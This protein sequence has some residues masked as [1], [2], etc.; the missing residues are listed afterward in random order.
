MLSNLLKQL[1]FTDNEAKVYLTLFDLGPSKATKIIDSIG[2]HRNLVYTS[3]EKLEKR[4]LV[5]K[6]LV[7]GIAEFSVSDPQILLEELDQQKE[8]AKQAVEELT[9]KQDHE[10]RDIQIFEGLEGI[11]RA[12]NRILTLP[13]DSD[14]YVL[15]A[16]KLTSFPELEAFWRKFHKER[17]LKGINQKMLYD[18]SDDSN[19]KEQMEWRNNLP[20]T[21]A[22]Q[23]PFR[24]DTPFWFDFAEDLINVG[25]IGKSPLTISIKSETLAKGLRQY[26]NF[27][28]NQKI[29]TTIGY[30]AVK[31]AFNNIV[32]E[33]K[34][35]EEYKVFGTLGEGYPKDLSDYFD[36]FHNN[37]IKKGV[38]VKM[39]CY[40][41]AYNSI[42]KRFREQGD[43]EGKI[44]HLKRYINAPLIPMQINMYN[45]KVFF[46]VYEEEPIVIHFDRP[47]IHDGFNNYFNNIWDQEFYSTSDPEVLQEL[48]LEAIESK[49]MRFIGA[50]GYFMD[51][52][53]ELFKAIEEKAKKT[54]DIKWQIVVDKETQGHKI[55]KFPWSH[56]KY[57][58]KVVKNPNA[59]WLFGNK[60]LIINWSENKPYVMISENKHLKQTYENY[61][62][63]LWKL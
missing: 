49:E 62:E 56:V 4:H 5:I 15:G 46:I 34:P 42:A 8:L 14:F 20:R 26:F 33:L 55:T 27:F 61:F 21:E 6:V 3:L 35:G 16:T 7:K 32:D 63:E 18:F 39:L 58:Q 23:L 38:V 54:K 9:K 1:N 11:K 37:R 51:Q 48:W 19:I 44:S 24:I 36:K 60:V 2:L 53:P 40:Q 22:K 57:T 10:T 50:R 59:V 12:R 13:S 47:S 31:T 43:P 28:W 45:N 29:T 17:E 41:E 25:F 30:E 52:Y